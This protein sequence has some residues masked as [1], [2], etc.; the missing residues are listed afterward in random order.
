MQPHGPEE[1]PD[2]L[3]LPEPEPDDVLEEL[4]REEHSEAG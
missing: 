3:A 2:P 1:L 4:L